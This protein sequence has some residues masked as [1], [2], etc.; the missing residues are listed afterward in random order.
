M[1][2]SILNLAKTPQFWWFTGHGMAIFCFVVYSVSL[3]FGSYAL[4][5]YNYCLH[6]IIFTYII[7]L[8]QTYLNR[9]MI[10][11]LSRYQLLLADDNVQYLSLLVLLRLSSRFPGP[12][13]TGLYPFVIFALFH[14][15]SYIKSFIIPQVSFLSAELKKHYI[16]IISNFILH[17]NESSLYVA[18]SF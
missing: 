9:S 12:L 4:S 15:L 18:S 2:N 6:A 5:W 3:L 14:A 13:P 8:R 10:Q 1:A 17:Y 11:V 16:S 7:V